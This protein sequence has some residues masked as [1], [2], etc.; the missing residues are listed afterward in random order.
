MTQ[1]F[2]KISKSEKRVVPNIFK[3]NSSV[4]ENL[5]LIA[6]STEEVIQLKFSSEI[7]L[8]KLTLN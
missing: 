5:C 2:H 8:Y 3:Y 1:V 6:F 4:S 7:H